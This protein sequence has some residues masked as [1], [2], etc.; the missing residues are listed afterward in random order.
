MTKRRLNTVNVLIAIY[1][2]HA[3]G[4]NFAHPITPSYLNYLELPSAMFGYVFAAMSLT[5]FMF[6][7]FWGVMSRY[8]NAKTLLLIGSVGYAIGQAIFGFSSNP[9]IIIIARFIS[10]AFV[11][12][13]FVG[14]GY[15]VVQKSQQKD[16]SKNITKMVTVFSVSGTIG[17]FLGGYLGGS[18][19]R[20]PF[21]VQVIVLITG[22]ILFYFLLEDNETEKEID[23]KR[24]LASSNPLVKSEKPLSFEFKILFL[25][26]FLISTAST[27]LT[28]TFSYYIVDALHMT[29]LVNGLTKGIVGLIS[30]ILNFTLTLKIVNSKHVERNT[31]ILFL[32]ISLIILPMIGLGA[33]AIVFTALGVIAMSFDTM[34]VSLL[35][36]RTVHYASDDSQGEMLGIHNAMRSLGMISGSLI[37][38]WL[39]DV[40][41]LSPFMLAMVLY[42]VGI[43][44]M[45]IIRKYV[46]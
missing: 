35:Q 37:A 5:N 7:P 41:G 1:A 29:S 19:L 28:Q 46:K 15:Y 31:M 36:G 38:G 40:N 17:Y 32:A 4:A 42:L 9:I 33:L 16:K 2:L 24:I 27:S 12:A 21:I 13:V 11:S 20:L 6:S 14:A 44:L 43:L 8:V 3:I 39:Y 45:N 34:P 22:G 18:S 23:M 26:V 30:L 25:T 10:G